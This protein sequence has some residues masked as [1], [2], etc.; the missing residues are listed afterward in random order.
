MARKTAKELRQK[1]MVDIKH[2][3]HQIT[4]NKPIEQQIEILHIWL[5]GSLGATL[6][7]Q[8]G[9]AKGNGGGHRLD[10]HI[11]CSVPTGFP[12]IPSSYGE[13]IFEARSGMA[14]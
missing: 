9:G 7:N 11:S 4:A 14:G 8:G 1:L 12:C 10:M 6:G 2:V 13:R 5:V 3:Q